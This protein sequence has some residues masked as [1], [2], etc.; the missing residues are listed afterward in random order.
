MEPSREF[1]SRIANPILALYPNVLFWDSAGTY[2]HQVT[3]NYSTSATTTIAHT[4]PGLT[5]DNRYSYLP[6]QYE[7]MSYLINMPIMKG[8]GSAVISLTFKN[9]F[10][11]LKKWTCGKLHDYVLPYNPKYSYDMNPFHDIY[12]NSNIKNKTVLIVGD[13]LFCSRTQTEGVPEV[14]STFG[15][16]FPNSLFLSTDPVAIDSVMFDFLKAEASRSDQSQRYLHRAAELG[17]GRHEHWNNATEKRYSIIDFKKID[18][19]SDDTVAPSRPTGL[20]IL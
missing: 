18:M 12:L 19:A 8:H 9:H 16:K 17:L 20:R 13:G 10:G 6:E 4:N 14:W 2:G 11:S 5:G 1:S 15:G 3:F 7:A